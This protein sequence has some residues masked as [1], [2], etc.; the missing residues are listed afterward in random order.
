L[1]GWPWLR[2]CGATRDDPH[3][4]AI[5][6]AVTAIDHDDP[7]RVDGALVNQIIS[8]AR[9]EAIGFSCATCAPTITENVSG[10]RRV[11]LQLNG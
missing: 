6:F 5:F 10:R 11:V 1:H 8:R 4:D 7:S 2:R 9:Y 3:L